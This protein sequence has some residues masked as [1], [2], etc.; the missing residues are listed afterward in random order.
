MAKNLT[1]PVLPV[2]HARSF[3]ASILM[4]A[5]VLCNAFQLDLFGFLDHLGLGATSDQ[6]LDRI[7]MIAPLAFGIWAWWERKAPHYRLSIDPF[8]RRTQLS[9]YLARL[10]ARCRAVRVRRDTPKDGE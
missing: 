5:T 4:A 6:V 8:E 7:M 10:W 1:L 3:Y 2:W 9:A